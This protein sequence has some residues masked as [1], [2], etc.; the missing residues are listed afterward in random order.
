VKLVEA[1]PPGGG[2]LLKRLDDVLTVRV[3]G[4]YR[5]MHI[6]F[7]PASCSVHAMCGT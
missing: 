1:E 5:E 3:G 7:L 4:A 2:V 6:R